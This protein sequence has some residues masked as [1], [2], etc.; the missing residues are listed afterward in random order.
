MAKLLFV[1]RLAARDLR[2]RPVETVLLLVAIVAATATL[3]LGLVLHGVT[4]SPYQQT[5]AATA[6][7]D[8][9]AKAWPPAGRTPASLTRLAHRPGVTR[10]AGPYPVAWP[11]IRAGRTA[12]VAE[13]LGRDPQPARLDQPRVTQG[14]WV[15]PGGVVVERTFAAAL[16]LRIGDR[17]TLNGRSFTV[18]GFA[19]S[20]AVPVYPNVCSVGC[21]F[22]YRQSGFA[23]PAVDTGVIWLTRA[24]AASLATRAAPLSYEIDLALAHPAS[25]SSFADAVDSWVTG[26]AG[27]SVYAWPLVRDQDSLLVAD[28]RQ[29]LMA[30][31]WLLGL[32]AVAS[33][34]VL[35]GLRMTEQTRRVGL[36]KAVGGTPALVAVVLLAEHAALALLAAAAGLAIGWLA[37]PLLTSP[38]VGL[39]GTP[40]APTLTGSDVALVVAAA[41]VVA[42]LATIVPAARAARTSTVAALADRPRPPRRRAW[43]LRIS[44]ALPV[45]LLLGLRLAARRPRRMVLT[46]VSTMLTVTDLVAVLTAHAAQDQQSG[47]A[48]A[49]LADPTFDRV[50]QVMLVLTVVLV[51]LA[52][53]TM[54]LVSWATTMDTRRT[55]A[56]T[57][58]LGASPAQVTS[59]LALAQ[60]LP[61]LPGALLGIPLGVALFAVVNSGGLVEAPPAW[62]VA[63]AVLGTL[64]ATAALTAIPARIDAR[65]PVAPLL[66]AETT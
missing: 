64:A 61:A 9:V 37:A 41:L 15:R 66:E 35:A 10:A 13:A 11:V 40:G 30:G 26:S 36:I 25:A 8:L 28:E 22:P 2:H 59:G 14:S 55:A 57:R 7:P 46:A 60:V 48:G 29:V 12:A 39:V 54:I 42:I 32:L 65:R 50:G 47:G 5:R 44:A 21:D 1:T 33:V 20:A 6:G 62:R 16:R 4:S 53:V 18:T 27:P 38:G 23:N 24:A 17:V 34:A 52:A 43:L 51:I 45:P 19:V 3:T 49:R 56:L 63:A 31:S 58:S